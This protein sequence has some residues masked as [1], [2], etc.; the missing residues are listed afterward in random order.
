MVIIWDGKYLVD[1]WFFVEKFK[2]EIR[3]L[4]GNFNDNS[5]DEFIDF[6]G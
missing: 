2:D 3:G 1:I 5:I 6:F 4:C